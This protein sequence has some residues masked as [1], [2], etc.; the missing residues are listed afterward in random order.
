MTYKIPRPKR[1][2]SPSLCIF[3]I[4]NPWTIGIG[5]ARITESVT[6]LK[7]A[8]AY[9]KMVTLKQIPSGLSNALSGGPHWTMVKMIDSTAYTK[10][11][12]IKILVAL[13]ARLSVK[14]QRYMNNMDNFVELSVAL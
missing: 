1:K 11:V 7:I 14:I 2:N 10:I 5:K 6:K 12:H 4:R 9:Q 13:R 8:L 3:L